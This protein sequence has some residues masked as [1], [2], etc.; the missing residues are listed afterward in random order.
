M[1]EKSADRK[2]LEAR[3]QELEVKFAANIGDDTLA[4][5]I[6]EAKKAKGGPQNTEAQKTSATADEGQTG[7]A[8]DPQAPAAGDP[9]SAASNTDPKA[10]GLTVIVKGPRQGR[11]RI[12]RHF[13]PEPVSIPAEELS[14]DE[15][16]ALIADPELTVTTVDAPY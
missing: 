10:S 16:R 4:E 15:Q 13:T 11:W 14:E 6:A 5:R 3:A 1:S 2:A 12:G 8:E 7:T 9:S